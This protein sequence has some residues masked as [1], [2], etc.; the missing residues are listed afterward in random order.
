VRLAFLTGSLVHGGAERHSITLVNR[1]AER[2][3]DCHA[4][5]V[6]DDHSQLERLQ[7]AA[8]VQCLEA[9][10]YLDRGALRRLAR[11]L[12]SLRP[13][14]IL[15][16]NPY[17]LLYATL[18]RRLARMRTPLAV[19]FHT[20]VPASAKEWLKMLY[21]RPFFWN[22]ERLVYVC[23]GQQR[24][25]RRRRLWGRS[26]AVIHNGVDPQ[27]WSPRSAQ[28]RATIRRVLGIGAHDYVVGMCAVLRPEKNHL[29]LVETIARLR[30]LGIAARAL[31]IGD[32]PMRAAVEA[33]ARALR[34]AGAVQI[35]GYQ[36]DV[37]APLAA[38]DVVALCSDAVETFSLAALE[39]MALERP[40]VHADIG[41][42]AEMIEP[43]A[44]GYLFPVHDTRALTE[45]LARLAAPEAREAMGRAARATVQA[46]FSEAAMVDRYENLLQELALTR[47]QREH[48]RTSATAH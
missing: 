30:A 11:A 25:W 3:H 43:G 19:T 1:L 45:R 10:R 6:K 41:G 36:Q 26:E 48:V 44:N 15:A 28:E 39:A 40:V 42:A 8:S 47:S 9:R 27:Y 46:R 14:A 24:Y 33:R 29:Q 7:G 38:C 23:E 35:T 20:T 22:A 18:A 12:K 17:A 37:R 34:L 21:Y 16:A 4:L 32:G 13:A 5:Y 2:R 31:L